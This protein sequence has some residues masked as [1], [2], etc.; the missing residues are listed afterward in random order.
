MYR[1]I[2]RLSSS[3]YSVGLLHTNAILYRVNS[4][5]YPVNSTQCYNTFTLLYRRSIR[6]QRSTFPYAKARLGLHIVRVHKQ[7]LQN[8]VLTVTG[9]SAVRRSLAA[10]ANKH[11]TG[12]YKRRQLKAKFHYTIHLAT[13]SRAGLRPARVRKL[14]SVMEFGRELLCDLLASKIA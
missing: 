4:V 2:D 8:V 5:F 3:V 7:K 13:S 10:L 11:L 6:Y 12:K 14:D 1:S 9:D